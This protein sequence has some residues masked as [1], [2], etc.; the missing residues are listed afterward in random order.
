MREVG[1]VGLTSNISSGF[2]ATA[3]RRQ[4]R[5]VWTLPALTLLRA[6]SYGL[7]RPGSVQNAGV[8]WILQAVVQWG[9]SPL[10]GFPASWTPWQGPWWSLLEGRLSQALCFIFCF[11]ALVIS[12]CLAGWDK[13]A[14]VEFVSRGYQEQRSCGQHHLAG[15]LHVEMPVVGLCSFSGGEH[16]GQRQRNAKNPINDC[17]IGTGSWIL[18]WSGRESLAGS[19]QSCWGRGDFE[20]AEAT[21]EQG[22]EKVTAGLFRCFPEGRGGPDWRLSFRSVTCGPWWAFGVSSRDSKR[23]EALSR[24]VARCLKACVQSV[25]VCEGVC[26]LSCKSLGW[27]LG[28]AFAVVPGGRWSHSYQACRDGLGPN[29]GVS[30]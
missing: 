3:G 9:P 26:F 24:T 29:R 6:F 20:S 5:R 19:G 30:I 23:K 1:R 12:P 18:L 21:L 27:K 17:P 25:F 14:L 28:A 13:P 22:M 11:V 7:F 16:A 15:Q 4:L 8:F 2:Q 10:A